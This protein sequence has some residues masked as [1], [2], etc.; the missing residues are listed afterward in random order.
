MKRLDYM[1][2]NFVCFVGE[3]YLAVLQEYFSTALVISVHS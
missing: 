2:D 1:F 3:P